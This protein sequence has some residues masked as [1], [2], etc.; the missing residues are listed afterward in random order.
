MNWYLQNKEKLKK[1]LSLFLKDKRKEKFNGI[2]VP[3]AG[4]QYSG[5]IAGKGF[6]FLKNSKNKKAIVLGPNHYYNIKGVFS[7]LKEFIETP[8]GKIKVS[9]SDFPQIDFSREHSIFNQIPFLQFLKYKEILPLIVSYISP[10]E[11]KN[12]AEKI[13][14]LEGDFVFSTDLSHFLPY[15][16]AIKKDKKTIMAIENLEEK[17]FLNEENSACGVF[18]LLILI[19]LCKINNWKPKLIQYK[20]SGDVTGDKSSVVGYASFIF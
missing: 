13:S 17:F 19:N 18:P 11:S 9:S 1:A 12:I 6:S 16:E 7:Y 2:I 5:E 20:N 3:H 8:L 15:E 14:K 4:Y 10:E